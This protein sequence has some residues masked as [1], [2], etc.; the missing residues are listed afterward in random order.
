M[1]V[2]ATMSGARL[3]YV[4]VPLDGEVVRKVNTWTKKA[5]LGEKYVDQPAGFM[6]YFPRGHVLRI[7]DR[8]QL[9]Q[10]KLDRPAQIINLQGLSDP[11]SPLG[12]MMMSQDDATRK[13]AFQSLED[14]V[15]KLAQAKSGKVEL[16]RDPRE[17]TE[18]EERDD[19]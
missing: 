5:G 10:Y 4:V 1:S 9:R 13:G 16:T 3:A 19:D 2:Q 6:V 17:L 14:Q 7:R 18:H 15:I 11:N 12:K 8:K